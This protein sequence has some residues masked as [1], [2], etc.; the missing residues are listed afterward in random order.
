MSELRETYEINNGDTLQVRRSFFLVTEV[1]EPSH[2]MY[3]GLVFEGHWF[4]NRRQVWGPKVNLMAP[5]DELWNAVDSSIF[6][7]LHF[8][9]YLKPGDL[10]LV[11]N[12]D[13]GAW[14]WTPE[15]KCKVMDFGEKTSLVKITGKGLQ[16]S[17]GVVYEVP[18]QRLYRRK[19]SK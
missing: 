5:Y 1:R 19:V 12:F 18:S 9:A 4:D 6:P 14:A 15:V 10:A 2:P 11:E 8:T 17:T 16:F 7:D 3:P 13:N